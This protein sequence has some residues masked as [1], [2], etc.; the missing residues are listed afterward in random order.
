MQAEIINNAKSKLRFLCFAQQ[1]SHMYNFFFAKS[2]HCKKSRQWQRFIN[3][4]C[5]KNDLVGI[6]IWVTVPPPTLRHLIFY[7]Q[8]TSFS[9]PPT[10]HTH[11]PH[12]TPTVHFFRVGDI[13]ALTGFPPISCCIF[14]YVICGPQGRRFWSKLLTFPKMERNHD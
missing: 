9:S 13:Q 14:L 1:L 2:S 3:I 10:T 5:L 7:D 11:S 8:T 12:H 6:P 4:S